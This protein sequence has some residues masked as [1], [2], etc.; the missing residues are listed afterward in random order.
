[1]TNASVELEPHTLRPTYRLTMGVP[2]RSYA[3]SVAARLG[4]P[5]EIMEQALSLL[6]PQHLRFEDWLRE[7]QGDRDLLK[8]KLEEAEKERARAEA[9][10]RELNARLEELALRREDM[11]HDMKEE[12]AARFEDVRKRLRRAEA[13][14]TWGASFGEVEEAKAEIAGARHEF[15]IAAASSTQEARRLE[16]RPV[17]AGDLVDVRGLNVR[18]TVVDV[19]ER[20]GEIEVAI[21]NVRFRLDSRRLTLSESQGPQDREGGPPDLHFDL[22]P[23]LETMELDVRGAR[24]QDALLSVEEFLDKALRDGMSSVRIVH[25]KGTGALR[26]A[27]RELLESHPLA[28][29]FAPEAPESGGDGATIVQLA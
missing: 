9:S 12:I 6:E 27:V 21:G 16:G 25:G 3:M 7:L 14:L 11:V 22:G 15:Q 19:P 13:A 26:R 4:L 18:G 5:G 17:A 28:K 10:Q 29:S 2:G 23:G 24:A 20:G 8:V 1:M